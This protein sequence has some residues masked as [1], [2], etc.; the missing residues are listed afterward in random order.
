M[1][2]NERCS[3]AGEQ[4]PETEFPFEFGSNYGH[5][6]VMR[7]EEEAWRRSPSSLEAIPPEAIFREL[8]P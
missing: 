8:G 4:P 3:Q 6:G 2:P 7:I 5:L 1:P